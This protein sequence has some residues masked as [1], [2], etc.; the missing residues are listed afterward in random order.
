MTSGLRKTTFREIRQSLGRFLAIAAIIALGVGFFSGL[1]VTTED[2]IEETDRY[3]SALDFHDFRFVSTLGFTDNELTILRNTEGVTAAYGEYRADAVT[4][5]LSGS[6]IPV[7]TAFHSISQEVNKPDLVSGRF[8]Q[9]ASEVML[10]ARSFSEDMIGKKIILSDINTE[11]T[12][13]QFHEREFTIVGLAHSPLYLNYE[14]GTT[15]LLSGTVGYYAF[16]LPEAYNMPAYTSLYCLTEG[17]GRIYS[18]AYKERIR[19]ITPKMEQ[20]LFDMCEARIESVRPAAMEIF[21]KAVAEE[22]ASRGMQVPADFDY[23]ANLPEIE[24]N[25]Y[26]LDRTSNVG[27]VCFENDAN[28]VKGIARVFPVFFILVAVLVVMTTMSR[29]VEEQRTQM[30]VLKALGYSMP[31]IALKYVIYSGAAAIAGCLIGFFSGCYIFPTVIWKVYAIM[32]GFTDD[33]VY[34]FNPVLFTISLIVS[35]LCSVG[36]TLLGINKELRAVPAELIRPRA[37]KNG[38]RIFFERI[39]FLWKRLPFLHKVSLRN[40]VRYRRRFFMMVIGIAGCTALLITGHGIRDSIVTVPKAQYEEIEHY[41][42]LVRLTPGKSRVGFL[43]ETDGK[44]LSDM[45]FVSYNTITLMAGEKTKSANLIVPMNEKEC[46]GFVTLAAENGKSIAFPGE[47]ECVLSGK[48]AGQLG[49][50]KGDTLRCRKEDG[51]EF[52]VRVSGV[53]RNYVGDLV[54][55]NT[56]TYTDG[57]GTEPVFDCCFARAEEGTDI[58]ETGGKLLAADSVLTVNVN[59]EFRD[60]I[61]KMLS[62]LDYIVILVNACAAALAFIVLYN[63]TNINITERLREIATI[64][65]L[66]F[67]GTETAMYVFRENMLLTAVGA[68]AGIPLGILLHKFVMSQIQVDMVAFNNHVG[69]GSFIVSMIYTFVFAVVVDLVMIRRLEKI[70]MAESMKSIE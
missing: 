30:G 4:E 15:A 17:G 57:V 38:K 41:D 59:R 8:P 66:G 55:M 22:Y 12:L 27:Y 1:K 25:S 68:L 64:K 62:S 65:V 35:I 20:C 7:V 60:R 11:D 56:K 69:T 23:E 21:R 50:G 34:V 16:L 39:T 28:I 45:T 67:Y 54:Y 52:T 58:Y 63:L 9:N 2:M 13:S 48:M 19:Q 46:S 51:A 6:G 3:L 44:L 61:E 24:C 33:L 42:Y 37:P 70:N 31:Q 49:V 53:F 10:E 29:M 18:E 5:P 26:L 32:Y 36:V 47:G 14:R 40:V 43:Q